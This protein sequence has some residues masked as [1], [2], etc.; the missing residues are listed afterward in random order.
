MSDSDKPRRILIADDSSTTRVLLEDVLSE[1]FKVEVAESGLQALEI[2]KAYDD[3]VLVLLDLRM[4]YDVLSIIHGDE[5]LQDIPVLAITAQD[6]AVASRLRL[7]DLGVVDVLTKPFNPQIVLRRVRNVV[8]HWESNKQVAQNALLREKLRLSEID[9]KTG[10]YNKNAFCDKVREMLLDEPGTRFVLFR[11]DI[12][13]FKVFNDLFGVAAGDKIL[14]G[15][16][17]NYRSS[18]TS[19]MVY[20][21]WGA[22]HFVA[23]M[24][25]SVFERKHVIEKVTS[26]F[27]IEYEEYEFTVR[28]GIYVIDDPTLDVSLM[29]DRALLALRSIKNDYTTRFAYYDDS[30][31]D[32]LIE[33]QRIASDMNAALEQ[34]QF[35]VYLQPQCNYVT[36]ALHGA[37]ALVRWQHPE[38]GLVM[39]DDFIPIFERN[40][41]I[42][43]MDE[44]VWEQV[45]RLQRAW[46]D[47]GVPVIPISVNVSRRDIY[48]PH[49]VETLT[50]LVARY[51]LNTSLLRLEITESAY[52]Q[53]ASQLIR[54]VKR[55]RAEGFAVEMDDFGSGYSSLN[56]LKEAPVDM[57]KLD[58][59]FIETNE[60]DVRGSSILTSVIRMAHW[61]DLPV[62]AEGVDT[63]AQAEYL[64]RVGCNYIQGHFFAKPMPSDEF[65][66]MLVGATLE[67]ASEE[68]FSSDVPEMEECLSSE[69]LA[70]IVDSAPGGI[71]EIQITDS[72]R[73]VD[74][75]DRAAIMFGFNKE[76]YARRLSENPISLIHPDDSQA[77]RD[78]LARL[79]TGE[80]ATFTI[81]YRHVC[82]DGGW[83]WVQ[84]TTHVVHADVEEKRATGILT[85]IDDWMVSQESLRLQ[86]IQL[87]RQHVSLKAIYDTVPCGIMQ[88]DISA[89]KLEG[90]TL[91]SFNDAAWQLC[92]Y[93]SRAE[94]VEAVRDQSKLK[95]VHPDDLSTLREVI[96]RVC[97]GKPDVPIDLEHRIIKTNRETRWFQTTVQKVRYAESDEMLQMV[98]I[99]VT[100]SK[101]G[102]SDNLS[103]ALMTAYDDV[104][105]VDLEANTAFIKE[106]TFHPKNQMAGHVLSYTEGLAEYCEQRV[107]PDDVAQIVS[108]FDENNVRNATFPAVIEYRFRNE[109]DEYGFS[110]AVMLHTH[111]S[112]Y[113]VCLRDITTERDSYDLIRENE[114]LQELVVERQRENERTRLLMES[115]GIMVFDYDVE[116]DTAYRQCIGADGS[117]EQTV[118][119]G[120]IATLGNNPI[121]AVSNRGS[122][123]D[124]IRECITTHQRNTLELRTNLF[125]DGFS[126]CWLS[127]APIV[128][129]EG[130]V[131]RLIG[132]IVSLVDERWGSDL[133]GRLEN[134]TGRDFTGLSF[135][136]DIIIRVLE[137]LK[138]SADISSGMQSALSVIGTRM[139]VCRAYVNEEDADG[140]H[141]SNTFEWYRQDLAPQSANRQHIAYPDGSRDGLT[142]LFDENGMLVCQDASTLSEQVRDLFVPIG[143]TAFVQCAI[144][145]AGVF[146]GYVGFDQCSG[147]RTWTK[148]QTNTLK[149]AA[150]LLSAYLSNNRNKQYTEVPEEVAASL[151][152]SPAFS[153]I[154]DPDTYEVLYC[155]KVVLEATGPVAPHTLCYRLFMNQ[156]EACEACPLDRMKK[157]G[158]P[159]PMIVNRGGMR[160]VM[161]AS[162]F[163]WHGHKAVL[164]DGTSE[165]TFKVDSAAL[166]EEEMD[167][168]RE[169]CSSML[170]GLYDEITELDFGEDCIRL[171]FSRYTDAATLAAE[172]A[173]LHGNEP[174]LFD[175][176]DALKTFPLRKTM[177]RYKSLITDAAEREA[178][179]AFIDLDNMRNAFGQ[180]HAPMLSYHIIGV[181]GAEHICESTL[182]QIGFG[183]YLNCTRDITE[184]VNIQRIQQELETMKVEAYAQECYRMV[185]EQTGTAV[186]D[187]NCVTGSVTSTDSYSRYEL[188]RQ[189]QSAVIHDGAGRS[190][191]FADDLDR[192]ERFFSDVNA[193]T[194]HVDDVI[195]LK[196][197]DGGFRWTR[198]GCDSIFDDDGIK[199]R[200]IFTLDDIDEEVRTRNEYKAMSERFELI[201]KN[202]PVGIAIYELRDALYPV[203]VSDK[204]CEMFGF[205]RDEYDVRIANGEPVNFMPDYHDLPEEMHA[206]PVAGQTIN[207]DHIRARRKDGSWFDLQVS[208]HNVSQPGRPLMPYVTFV[209]ITDRMANE[210]RLAAQER[211][212]AAITS[213]VP[214]GI[215]KYSA[216]DDQFSFVSDNMLVMLGYT[217]EEFKQKFDNSFT[218]MVYVEDRERTIQKI[219]DDIAITGE[220][221]TC[222]YRIEMKSGALKW[223][224][225]V[226]RLMVDEDGLRWFTV[227][228]VD[229][230]E[231][232]E[233][234]M[235]LAA[236]NKY[237]NDMIDAIPGGI[238][239]F[240]INQG[241]ITRSYLNKGAK[242]I[243]GY[244]ENDV[245]SQNY[246]ELMRRV[247]PDDRPALDASIDA[248][249]HDETS[250]SYDMSLIF[251]GGDMRWINLTANPVK[252]ANPGTLTYYG[253]YTD[254]TT[255]RNAEDHALSEA[256]VAKIDGV[257]GVKNRI[258]TEKAIR[259]KLED[260]TN[261]KCALFIT[262]LD[263]MKS[264]NDMY[265]HIQGDKALRMLAETFENTF[266]SA[267]IVGRI[268]GDE[269]MIFLSNVRG[270][271]SLHPVLD[272][273]LK[274]L[275]QRHIGDLPIQCS[276]GCALGVA[277]SSTFEELYEKADLALYHVKRNGK[278]DYVFYDEQMA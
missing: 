197:T 264:I 201:V 105:E 22:D 212:L 208:I 244:G 153:Y 14:A 275:R 69:R 276:I 150:V 257:T 173:R 179:A 135:E 193:G 263:D 218:N 158:V 187:C 51:G 126:P 90:N 269:F 87:K 232:K 146:C 38:R 223:V 34:G 86:T 40:G 181:D 129:G 68:P 205:T 147:T 98:F 118:T 79:T 75:N 18:S 229:I 169:R 184:Q 160:Y 16:G 50:G 101:Q 72:P 27:S 67:S 115:T 138:S 251:D 247:N 186:V 59:K 74:F 111:G 198:M 167:R 44:Y 97:V 178:F 268:G 262:D 278:G 96:D 55:L 217:H 199:R 77:F 226:G 190:C 3:I 227:V 133:L 99:D 47:K 124:A 25:L 28:A 245:P 110:S 277:G 213:G 271:E 177:D 156:D 80:L 196:M 107:H 58:M 240:S 168:D 127:L 62:I 31:R 132:Q 154:I 103:D 94:Y 95:D 210:S 117:L 151:D 57:L 15:I 255:R 130:D 203:F 259:S 46:I 85:D 189:D 171:L 39:P 206:K 172:Q 195:R 238:V 237:I 215:F 53:D 88:F 139:N 266:R 48:N 261:Q 56:T 60:D 166:R 222:E 93:A 265:G 267:D 13:H 225:D 54:V 253:V 33:E 106:S 143:T 120:F 163:F 128:N 219:W 162:P 131:T 149:V 155:N 11:W 170:S 24:P 76:E 209:D 242:L 152:E 164:V 250:F 243:L 157:A 89:G 270:E 236:S 17:A 260:V 9:E 216:D 174:S 140:T 112:Q 84:F 183:R 109:D 192:L 23:C 144:M 82:A 185:V 113:L 1:D 228:I 119:S 230:D 204:T 7:F 180:G 248:A 92:G 234:E 104:V 102:D 231:R 73:V 211:D 21:H 61:I 254:V 194:P 4:R 148:R 32:S 26:P 188:S 134:L 43:K 78:N 83:R 258:V 29:C 165:L 70:G 49:L 221:D 91:V 249:I 233:L 37:E 125:S 42:S 20:G 214:G 207:I 220:E 274:K 246:E 63:R 2:L 202:L 136:H 142:A 175:P 145:E 137:A 71:Y 66:E 64:K 161:Q 272:S 123:R 10:I 122:L 100:D 45:C 52:V 256:E 114:R 8:A 65:E 81:R 252:G 239:V 30:M 141:H 108:F 116:T 241:K 36:G 235:S 41:F 191:V 182:L 176:T 159:V 6:D 35:V 12:D 19:T 273:L 224:H 200:V 121:F 5:H